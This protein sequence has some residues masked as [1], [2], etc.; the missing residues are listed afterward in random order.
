VIFGAVGSMLSGNTYTA[1]KASISGAV[2]VLR[3][4]GDAKV[5]FLEFTPPNSA[6]RYGCDWHPGMD[7]QAAMA[8]RLETAIQKLV[9][10][11]PQTEAQPLQVWSAPSGA[12]T[13]SVQ[14]PTPAAAKASPISLKAPASKRND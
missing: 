5:Q 14:H 8:D 4:E 6:R 3:K 10:W 2:D 13:T 9:G 1:A 11:T 7:A 12:A